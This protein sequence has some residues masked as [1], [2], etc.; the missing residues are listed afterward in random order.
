[1]NIGRPQRIIEID[2]VSLPVPDLLPDPEPVPRP[3]PA[4]PEPAERE[5]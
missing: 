1:M 4:D 2:P 3:K 5:R